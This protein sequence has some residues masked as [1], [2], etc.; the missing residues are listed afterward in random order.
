[1]SRQIFEHTWHLY[2]SVKLLKQAFVD[3]GDLDELHSGKTLGEEVFFLL[4]TRDHINTDI[5]FI[6]AH[7]SKENTSF[8]QIGM[9]TLESFLF[10]FTN[11][12]FRF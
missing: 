12:F 11:G 2:P 6:K 4:N 7:I 1:M 8:Q 5:T 9:L 10:H 3:E